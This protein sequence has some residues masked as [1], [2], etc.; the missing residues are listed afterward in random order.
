[1][2]FARHRPRSRGF[3]AL[4]AFIFASA[5]LLGAAEVN[6]TI[7]ITKQI[8][9]QR[10]A[11]VAGIYHRG[12]AVGPPAEMAEFS[13]S[14]LTRSAVYLEGGESFPIGNVSVELKQQNRMF[15]PETLVIP[16]GA[17]VSFPNL[18]PIF[19][20]VFSFSRP[21]T[22]DLGNYPQ[23]E[24][25]QVTFGKPGIVSVFCHLHS[26]MSASIVVAPSR[27]Y[28]S[29]EADGGYALKDVPPGNYTLVFWHKT[30]G[31]FRRKIAVAADAVTVNFTIPVSEEDSGKRASR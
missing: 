16:V 20:N 1:M 14:E 9:R 13:R 7:A 2:P 22:F 25:R 17:T 3:A 4:A 29:P 23:G 26:N 10:V 8:T 5:G 6:G 24:T 31:F 30:A 11:P 27:W 18:D 15:L 19:H 28:A 12:A 21:S